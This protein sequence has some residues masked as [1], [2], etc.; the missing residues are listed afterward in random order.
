MKKDRTRRK[1]VRFLSFIG[2][3]V[4]VH[5][6]HLYRSV[7]DKDSDQGDEGDGKLASVWTDPVV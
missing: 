3:T 6:R 2:P 7:A 1:V 5:G 4:V